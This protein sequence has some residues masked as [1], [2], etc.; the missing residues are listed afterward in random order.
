[1]TTVTT[2]IDATTGGVLIS[3][4]APSS[5]AQPITSYLIEIADSLHASWYADTTLCDGS[6]STV[7]STLSCV[8]PMNTLT[9]A[10][11][12]YLLIHLL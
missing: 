6:S 9:S 1:M 3:W 5:N 11:Y 2:S 10:P 8:I 12:N 4:T 7:M